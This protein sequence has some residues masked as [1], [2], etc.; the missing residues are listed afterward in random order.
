MAIGGGVGGITGS[1]GLTATG[2]GS[3]DFVVIDGGVGGGSVT[4]IDAIGAGGVV[5]AS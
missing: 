3:I 5:V 2:V 4:V 1:A